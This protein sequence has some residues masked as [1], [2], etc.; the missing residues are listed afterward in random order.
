[1]RKLV[2]FILIVAILAALMPFASAFSISENVTTN[3]VCPS[4]TIVLQQTV[5]ADKAG[6]FTVT[7]SGTAK[8]FSTTVPS[9]FFLGG[10]RQQTIYT[11]ITPSSKVMPGKYNIKIAVESN[12][13]SK[14]V[15]HDLIVE[16]CHNAEM[17]LEPE[18][19][20]CACEEKTILLNIENNGKYLENYKLSAE[21]PAS[22]WINLSAN[23]LTLSPNSSVSVEA[24]VKT[25]CDVKGEYEVNFVLEASPYAKITKNAKI[26][27]ESCYDYTVS[28]D[29]AL[30]SVCGGNATSIPVKIKNLG[31]AQNTYAINVNA[32]SWI[33]SDQ[34]ELSID[35]NGEK[36]FN[37]VSSPSFG[38][39]G[40][41]TISIDVL[42]DFGKVMKKLEIEQDVEKCYG[43]SVAIEAEK[44]KMCSA[45]GSSY[46]I[47][48]RNTGRF[49]NTYDLSVIGPE[50][51]ALSNKSVT[52]NASAQAD[53]N[54]A[55]KPSF[56]TTP[57]IYNIT[58]SAV[59]SSS[60]AGANDTISIE[61]I[62]AS[63]CYSPAINSQNDS[64]ALSR[65]T[66]ATLPLIVENKGTNTANY[67]IEISGTASGFCQVNPGA[68]TVNP[69]EAQTIY[70]YIAPSIEA[71]PGN[72]VLAVTARLADTT[73]LASKNIAI[74]VDEK[75]IPEI[76]EITE[77]TN[78]TGITG[79]TVSNIT[80][81]T[82]MTG[83]NVTNISRIAAENTT[84]TAQ[85][86]L[87][88]RFVAWLGN[89]FNR[90]KA[91]S[92]QNISNATANVAANATGN[93][94]NHAPVLIKNI[95]DINIKSGETFDLDLANYFS[96]EDKD[97]LT[98][99]SIKPLHID[100]VGEGSMVSITPEDN[101]TG[102]INTTF[103]AYDNKN[104]TASNS[105]L[106]NVNVVAANLTIANQT[107]A[108]QTLA[109]LTIGN[110][111]NQT[112]GNQTNQT[113]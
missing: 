35:K 19:K 75:E 66:T 49:A 100:F 61:T 10:N 1:M 12:G 67:S 81:A 113:A 55:V 36:A 11:Y 13:E 24:Y 103:Y 70:V 16:N 18:T 68:I 40:N 62:S 56:D 2:N 26:S 34:R 112:S 21:G 38:T 90:K 27:V 41:F 9:G 96:D 7:S 106:I 4:S 83:I 32:P 77:I 95:S 99:I 29:K 51:A 17:N 31:A 102:T 94:T 42:S 28:S 73:I 87:W 57:G 53:V 97:S 44:D 8:R 47:T 80:N 3:V 45:L 54:L 63:D 5:V 6:P 23:S 25:P 37:L 108:N 101:F 43:A 74:A 86:S 52:L 59:D 76:E 93:K 91:T 64:I 92:G 48:I 109:N 14:Y 110:Q 85:P 22:K 20:I 69:D 98:Y 30:Y 82:N 89:I 84:K 78:T 65:D 15:E 50:W 39:E 104:M 107:A 33:K 105:V 71:K 79:A 58:V 60:K 46:S 88:S 111:T 72:Y